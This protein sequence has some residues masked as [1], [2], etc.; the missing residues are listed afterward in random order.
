[1][2]S[3]SGPL[4]PLEYP[5]LR[6]SVDQISHYWPPTYVIIGKVPNKGIITNFDDMLQVLI[7]T[8][9]KTMTIRLMP[10]PILF[11]MC[12]RTIKRFYTVRTFQCAKFLAHQAIGFLY[13][14]PHR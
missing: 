12:R 10:F 1:M 3:P 4:R 8:H 6:S 2:V 13:L 11:L 14:E 5:G 9:L 7:Y